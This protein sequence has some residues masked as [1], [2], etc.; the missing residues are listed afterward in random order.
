MQYPGPSPL[1]N[2]LFDGEDVFLRG[3]HPS[4]KWDPTGESCEIYQDTPGLLAQQS[5]AKGSNTGF[6]IQGALSIIP[7]YKATSLGVCKYTMHPT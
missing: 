4:C 7:M 3:F 1:Q 6:E 5:I 2:T